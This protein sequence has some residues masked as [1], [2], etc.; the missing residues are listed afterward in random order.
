MG[1]TA[2][3]SGTD[4]LPMVLVIAASAIANGQLVSVVGYYTPCLI[5][6]VCFTIMGAGL[7]TTLAVDTSQ[8]KWI[9][10]QILYGFGLGL[11]SQAPNMAAQTVLR[12]QDVAIGASLLFFA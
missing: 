9:G 5:I 11:A 4:L 6:G 8:G 3:E 2:V 1:K 7:L 12:K 10:Y